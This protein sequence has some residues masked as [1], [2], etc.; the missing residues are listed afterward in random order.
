ME[1]WKW[2]AG[3]LGLTAGGYAIKKK[4]DASALAQA[5]SDA[6]AHAAALQQQAEQHKAAIGAAAQVAIVRGS[7][8]AQ[9]LVDQFRALGGVIVFTAPPAA[10]TATLAQAAAAVPVP[11]SFPLVRLSSPL[12]SA[13]K[14]PLYRVTVVVHFPASMAAN[15][16]KVAQNARDHGFSDAVASTSP[17]AGWPGARG[18]YYVTGHYFRDPTD[19]ARSYASGQVQIADA[20][21]GP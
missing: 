9:G 15:A 1:L 10:V 8:A 3:G 11:A 19:M 2:I 13:R 14:G 17:P 21:E 4:L 18:D 5:Q 12:V 6:A 16:D 7:P 20:W